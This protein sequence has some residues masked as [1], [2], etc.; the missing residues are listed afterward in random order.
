MFA[1]SQASKAWNNLP[2][3]IPSKLLTHWES[4][5]QISRKCPKYQQAYILEMELMLLQHFVETEVKAMLDKNFKMTDYD[6]KVLVA[7]A[8]QVAKSVEDYRKLVKQS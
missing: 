6:S 7:L 2:S 5:L 1:F 3:V 8:G 4:S